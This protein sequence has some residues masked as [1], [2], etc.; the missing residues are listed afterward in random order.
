MRIICIQ[1]YLHRR[2]ERASE[3]ISIICTVIL[4][5]LFHQP[6]WLTICTHQLFALLLSRA[7]V[8]ICTKYYLH[9]RA[10]R[11]SEK[12]SIICTTI[13][14]VLFIK[15]ISLQFAHTDYLYFCLVLHSSLFA[16]NII[17]I[18]TRSAPVEI[19][20]LFTHFYLFYYL[21]T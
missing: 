10:K 16:R 15:H 9:R 19:S 21:T 7:Y 1:Y 20:V 6:H 14:F 13:L 5:A 11:A 2:A 18:G 17:C 4:F 8:T 12:I 3:K